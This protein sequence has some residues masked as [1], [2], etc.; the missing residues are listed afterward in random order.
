MTRTRSDVPRPSA[1]HV[2]PARTKRNGQS[3]VLS[4]N[5]LS[6][7]IPDVCTFRQ[8]CDVEVDYLNLLLL[9]KGRHTIATSTQMAKRQYIATSIQP[10]ALRIH[11]KAGNLEKLTIEETQGS[12]W[13]IGPFVEGQEG[14]L[15]PT[16]PRTIAGLN[17]DSITCLHAAHRASPSRPRVARA[18]HVRIHFGGNNAEQHTPQEAQD[19]AT[20]GLLAAR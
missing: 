9:T 15:W 6:R 17:F 13:T 19:R 12:S 8:C 4:T 18:R 14:S 20:H 1:M 3:I 2:A 5:D 16:S 7:H 10:N 11:G